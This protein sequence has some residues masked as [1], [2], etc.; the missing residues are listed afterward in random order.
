MVQQI[1]SFQ[2]YWTN[3][4]CQHFSAIE[5]LG[6]D[7]LTQG[8]IIKLTATKGLKRSPI[9][10]YYCSVRN[11]RIQDG[12]RSINDSLVYAMTKGI[13][14]VSFRFRNSKT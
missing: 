6:F 1:K 4:R 10:K 12:H 14:L 9:E 3:V 7:T 13:P 5:S 11:V 8:L 2:I